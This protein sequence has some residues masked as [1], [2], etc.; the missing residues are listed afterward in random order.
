MIIRT[1]LLLLL[2][3]FIVYT[4]QTREHLMN[5]YLPVSVIASDTK[6][7]LPRKMNDPTNTDFYNKAFT[8]FS[9]AEVVSDLSYFNN[10]SHILYTISRGGHM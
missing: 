3:I 6:S 8:N 10:A 5:Q 7:Y 4:T 9:E 1:F 2:F